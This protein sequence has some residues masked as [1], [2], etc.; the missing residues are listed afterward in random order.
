[1]TYRI[2]TYDGK[3]YIWS[4]KDGW[5]LWEHIC[6]DRTADGPAWNERHGM[7]PM[8]QIV[9]DDGNLYQIWRKPGQLISAI[10]VKY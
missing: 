3:D 6:I 10:P 7:Q 1:M 2:R 9:A 4:Y 8:E 5:G